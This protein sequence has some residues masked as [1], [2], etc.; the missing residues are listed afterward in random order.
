MITATVVITK[1]AITIINLIKLIDLKY[2]NIK[3]ISVI[4][5]FHTL[6]HLDTFLHV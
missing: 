1:Y 4:K 6:L 5:I 2:R 3:C